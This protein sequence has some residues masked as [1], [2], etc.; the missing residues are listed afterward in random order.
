[1]NPLKNLFKLNKSKVK[2]E[3]N[4]IGRTSIGLSN[5]GKYMGLDLHSDTYASAYPSIRATSNEYMT[6]LPKAIDGNGKPVKSNILDALYHPN[7]LDSVVSFN[8][9]IATS[10]LV[11]PKTYLL[12]WRNERGEAR[13]GGDFGFKGKNIAGFTFLENPGISRRDGKT[14]YNVGSQWFTEDEVIVLDGGVDPHNLYGGYSPTEAACR[15][16]TLDD[17]IADFQKGFFENNAIPAGMF[18]ISAA[19]PTEFEDIVTNLKRRHKGAGNNNNVTYSHA[20]VDPATG[21]VAEAKIEWIPF[22]QSNKDIDFKSLFEQANHRIDQ[23]YGVPAIVKGIDDA[24][25]YANAQVAEAGFAKRAVLP[26]LTRNYAQITH[27]LNRITGGMGIAITFDYEIPAVADEEK[28]VAE[29]HVIHANLL[30][31]LET[32]GY[33]LDSIVDAFDLPKRLKLLKKGEQAAVIENDKPEVDEGDEVTK[34]PDPE[35]IDGVSPLNKVEREAAKSKNP[36]AKLTDEDK[37][38]KAAEKYLKKQ[39]ERA[40]SEYAQETQS[41]VEPDPTQDEEDTFVDEAMVAIVAILLAR[42]ILGYG[43]AEEM[44]IAAGLSTA[45]V[46]EYTLS[47]AARS[48]YTNYMRKVAQSYGTDTA[49]SIRAVLARGEAE[50]WTSSQMKKELR[51]ITELDQWRVDRLVRTELNRSQQL[52]FIE[53]VKQIQADTGIQFEKSL[54]HD[55]TPECEWCKS[56]EGVWFAVAEPILPLNGILIGTDGGILINDFAEND[57]YDVHP[58]GF[59]YMITRVKQTT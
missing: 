28:V 14:Y 26:L 43:E 38:R 17:Y 52:G 49:K 45:Q 8:E 7:Q 4:F 35:K 2:N 55:G 3:T 9:K 41:A 30:N 53:G 23:A 16:I 22:Q 40:V 57:G 46:S 39:V 54:K 36:K 15:W 25:T 31:S 1:M 56:L 11:L 21:K 27:E 51:R 47:E 33:S 18:K 37:L 58:N 13:P 59:G 10:T 12:V 50:G 19:T 44:L 5:P 42:G 20:P 24:A 29:T 6:V 34:S 32:N 48:S